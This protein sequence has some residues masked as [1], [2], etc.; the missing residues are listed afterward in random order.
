MEK[1]WS[2]FEKR[3]YNYDYESKEL[4]NFHEARSEATPVSKLKAGLVGAGIGGGAGALVGALHKKRSPE[5]VALTA[6]VGAALGGGAGVLTAI[7]D[8]FGIEEAKRITAMPPKEQKEYLRHLARTHEI[9]SK[10]LNDSM[11]HFETMHALRG[12]SY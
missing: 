3:A 6:L 5:R 7:G 1:F 4:K 10:E 12:L 8:K 2:G 11:R 9:S